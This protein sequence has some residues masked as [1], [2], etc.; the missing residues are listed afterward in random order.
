MCKTCGKCF[1]TNR[2]LLKHRLWH[3]KSELPPFQFNCDR[4]PYASNA[5]GSLSAHAQ[6][7]SADRAFKCIF[8]K[9]SFRTP[10]SLSTHVVIHTGKKSVIVERKVTFPT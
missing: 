5:K 1:T 3:H 7:H 6:V 9:N 4:C 8:C 2:T 10:R